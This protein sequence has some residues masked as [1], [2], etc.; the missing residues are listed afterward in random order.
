M[1]A[2]LNYSEMSCDYKSSMVWDYIYI[3][4]CVCVCVCVIHSLLNFFSLFS[5]TQFYFILTIVFFY[6]E[7]DSN[8]FKFINQEQYENNDN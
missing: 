8:L 7:I 1:I 3:Y 6:G 4:V 5:S 2:F